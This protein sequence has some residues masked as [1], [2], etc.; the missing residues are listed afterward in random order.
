MMM[1]AHGGGVS[2]RQLKIEKNQVNQI[3]FAEILGQTYFGTRL[4][5]DG[6]EWDYIMVVAAA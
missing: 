3:F 6:D 4:T 5:L 2:L 1:I